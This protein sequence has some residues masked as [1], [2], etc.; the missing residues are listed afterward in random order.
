MANYSQNIQTVLDILRN[1][2]DGDVKEALKKMSSEYTMTWV[3]H[4]SNSNSN[5]V[6]PST[7]TDM[8]SELGEAYVIRGRIYDIRNIAEGNNT[9]FVELI[10]SYPDQKTGKVFRTPLVLVLEMEDGK[11]KTGR[12]YCDPRL[13]GMHLSASQVEEAFKHGKGSLFEIS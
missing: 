3:Y 7:K 5:E 4:T 9:V 8:E 1:E 2:V 10:E 13:S 6:F 12:H 11:I